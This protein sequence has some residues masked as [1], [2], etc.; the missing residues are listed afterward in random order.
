M[1]TKE[2]R[3]KLRRAPAALY[4]LFCL[5]KARRRP[6]KKDDWELREESRRRRIA[7]ENLAKGMLRYLDY[8]NELKVGNTELKERLEVLAHI[9]ISIQQ[10]AQ[11]AMNEDGQNIFEVFWQEE[12]KLFVASWDRWEAQRKGLVDLERRCQDTSREIQMLNKRQEIFQSAIEGKLRVQDRASERLHDQIIE[13]MR[14]LESTKTEKALQIA[15]KEHDL[16]IYQNEKEEAKRTWAP[17]R[18]LTKWP[19]TGKR[20]ESLKLASGG[21]NQKE[22]RKCRKS[23]SCRTRWKA[24]LWTWMAKA[25][26]SMWK[27]SSREEE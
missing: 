5:R 2:P 8:Y 23:F 22:K 1:G 13:D 26:T 9:G 24:L 16:C 11:Q 12:G 21:W 7:F 15:E 10:V 17:P 20:Q 27:Q 4:R 19:D 25:D 3:Q 6:E 14:E 18:N